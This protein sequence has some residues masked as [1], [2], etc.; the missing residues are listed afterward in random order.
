ML[1][2]IELSIMKV[3]EEISREPKMNREVKS[4]T[5]LMLQQPV[6]VFWSQKLNDFCFSSKT[7]K[8]RPWHVRNSVRKFLH[9]AQTPREQWNTKICHWQ[10]KAKKLFSLGP[11]SEKVGEMSKDFVTTILPSYRFKG[12]FNSLYMVHELLTPKIK[13]KKRSL[14]ER[15]DNISVHICQNCTN[16]VCAFYGIEILFQFKN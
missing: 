1:L 6:R 9:K 5:C 8:I 14:L 12:W 13:C 11:G 4:T 7:G 15:G 10:R 16:K 2:N 3:R